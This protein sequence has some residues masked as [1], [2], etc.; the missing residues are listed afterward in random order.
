VSASR[1]RR[2]GALVEV[3]FASLI[4]LL[5]LGIMTSLVSLA[6]RGIVAT[7][8]RSQAQTQAR[9]ASR[10]LLEDLGA[11]RAVVA[12]QTIGGT[13]YATG[14]VDVLVLDLPGI[15]ASGRVLETLT[16]TVIYRRDANRGRL[17]LTVAPAAGSSRASHTDQPLVSGGVVRLALTFLRRATP[18][19]NGVSTSLPLGFSTPTGAVGRAFLGGDDLIALGTAQLQGTNLICATAPASGATIDV[20]APTSLSG[21]P[22]ADFVR[23]TIEV[24]SGDEN[25]SLTVESDL[26]N[27]EAT[28]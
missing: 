10:L 17:L 21:A 3:V 26:R 27:R 15:D 5:L 18:T 12:S 11:A 19:G 7:Q 8:D 16:D 24:R 22:N 13:T 6:A 9:R 25:L 4:A 14:D 28:P 1:T 23:A 20:Q 2:G